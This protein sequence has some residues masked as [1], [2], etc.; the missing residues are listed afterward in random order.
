MD[1]ERKLRQGATLIAVTGVGIVGYGLTF[2]YAAYLGT[3]FEPG[4]GALD[5]ATKADLAASS[6]ETLHYV[7]HLHVGLGGLLV[8]LGVALGALG[9]YG[10]RRGDRWAVASSLVVA[11]T[12][13]ST[14]AL[15]HHDPGF[16]YDWLVHVAPSL[17]VTGLVLAG[18]WRAAQGLHPPATPS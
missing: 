13:L 4:V 8:A 9:W 15:V 10:V 18:A 17:L 16:G 14:N 3:E 2:P 7:N 1:D 5:G 11:L 12:A 6:P